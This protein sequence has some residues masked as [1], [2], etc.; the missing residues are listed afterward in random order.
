[1]R[2]RPWPKWKSHI[3]FFEKKCKKGIFWWFSEYFSNI[4]LAEMGPKSFENMF[5]IIAVT[6]TWPKYSL[7]VISYIYQ[8][9]ILGRSCKILILT[10]CMKYHEKMTQNQSFKNP[11]GFSQTSYS[12]FGP[13]KC[14]KRKVPWDLFCRK[15]VGKHF[16]SIWG[17]FRPLEVGR[18][19]NL[20]SLWKYEKRTHSFWISASFRPGNASTAS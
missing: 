1:M 17:W 14:L 16:E 15:W 4:E 12:D 11:C 2:F 3:M 8:V 9:F 5:S 10:K 19:G 13:K 6:R 18:N 20:T 7:E